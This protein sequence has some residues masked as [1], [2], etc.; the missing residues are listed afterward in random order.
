M[1]DLFALYSKI[2]IASPALAADYLI[3]QGARWKPGPSA[4]NNAYKL[5]K[6]LADTG[7]LTRHTGY[8]S[9]PGCK[10]DWKNPHVRLLSEALVNILK[11]YPQS[12]AH[13][14]IH[15]PQIGV[16]ADSI[17][18]I[19]NQNMGLCIVLELLVTETNPEHKIHTW[20][21]WE[22]SLEYL[23]RLF[24]VKIPS[25]SIITAKGGEDV[26]EKLLSISS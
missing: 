6:E 1:S 20:E 17:I 2:H 12:V 10:S 14:E 8:F 4:T 9:L 18:L 5:L 16:R 25:F 7:Q 15:V 19:K 22:G 13:R 26:C 21:G 23:S 3:S 24:G 11:T